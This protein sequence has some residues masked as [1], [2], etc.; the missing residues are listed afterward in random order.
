MHVYQQ[1]K[2]ILLM[3]SAAAAAAHAPAGALV[4]LSPIVA[5]TL[6]GTRTLAGMLAGALVSGVQVAVSMSN[7]GG[8]WDNAK[9]YI[10]VSSLRWKGCRNCRAEGHL[11]CST[12]P[13]VLLLWKY[14]CLHAAWGVALTCAA[15]VFSAMSPR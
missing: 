14:C 10:E 1:F 7:T 8:A 6:F 13:V 12:K 3:Y 5:G 11:L 9:K 2:A 15:H 4:M